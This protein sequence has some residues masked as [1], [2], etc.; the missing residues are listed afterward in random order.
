M[1]KK[2]EKKEFDWSEIIRTGHQLIAMGDYVLQHPDD[3]EGEQ[4]R[5][6]LLSEDADEILEM[7][8]EFYREE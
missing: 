5:L 1:E 2:V 4:L 6:N 7:L 8:E 3:E